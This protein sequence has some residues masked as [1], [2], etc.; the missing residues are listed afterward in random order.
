MVEIKII[1]EHYFLGIRQI[2][3][4]KSVK[5]QNGEKLFSIFVVFTF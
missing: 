2:K 5:Y 1:A 3:Y 4:E